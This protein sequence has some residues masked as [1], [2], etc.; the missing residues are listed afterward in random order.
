MPANPQES[1]EQ[2]FAE[3][4]RFPLEAVQFVREGL[5]QAVSR[6]YRASEEP[7]Q[8]RH[9]SGVQLCEG[10]RELALKRWGLMS[11]SVLKR[12]HINNT[13]DFG[14][15]VFLLVKHG[16][17]QKRPEDRIE[18]FDEVYDFDVVFQRHFEIS[19]DK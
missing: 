9:I 10:L 19:L 2:I 3:D 12:W 1:I 6:F 5:N 4:G 13:R 16:W 8:P 11:R 7:D 17:M 14:E 15:I 18:D